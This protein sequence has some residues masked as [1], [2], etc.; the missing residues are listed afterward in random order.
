VKRPED[1]RLRE[2]FREL[3]R[4]ESAGAPSF[5]RTLAAARSRKAP[6]AFG[7]RPL[8]AAAAALAVTLWFVPRLAREPAPAA[9]QIGSLGAWTTSTDVLLETPGR[10]LLRDLPQWEIPRA[11]SPREG[12]GST[13]RSHR[14]IRV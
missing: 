5:A 9:A 2:A 11:S 14:R 6:R 3:R 4:V 10:D 8:A 13:S 7:W 1:T 12:D